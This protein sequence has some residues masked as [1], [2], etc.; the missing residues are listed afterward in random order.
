MKCQ[1]GKRILS[2]LLKQ[3][4]C[5]TEGGGGEFVDGNWQTGGME[6]GY[7]IDFFPASTPPPVDQFSSRW[8]YRKSQSLRGKIAFSYC[9]SCSLVIAGRIKHWFPPFFHSPCKY[10]NV[11]QASHTGFESKTCWDPCYCFMTCTCCTLHLCPFIPP[12]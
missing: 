5:M 4:K 3:Y 1:S 11:H 12:H 6:P 9:T 10:P 2:K 7:D 8:A